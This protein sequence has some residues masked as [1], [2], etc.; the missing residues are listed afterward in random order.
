MITEFTGLGHA[1]IRVKDIDAS[2]DFY[3]T[4]LGF[5]EMLRLHRDNG[6]LWLV[7][8]RVTDTQ[9]IE[10]FPYAVG[11]RAQPRE[12]V[13]LNHLCLTV[14]NIDDTVRQLAEIGI[15]LIQPLVDGACGNRQAWIE[16]PDGNRFELM[17]M[18]PES[19]QLQAIKRMRENATQSA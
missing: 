5:P 12:Q 18:R 1:A 8:I 4:K 17:Q 11:E 3:C 10:L 6:D 15:P 9:Y 2:L 7:Y 19:M 13:G 16:D 14:K